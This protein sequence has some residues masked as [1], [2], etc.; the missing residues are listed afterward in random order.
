MS[1]GSDIRKWAEKAK[2]GTDQVIRAS[3]IDVSTRII[4]RTPVG[5]PAQWQ[6]KYP[7]KGYV[8]GTARGNWFASINNPVTA[9]S[10]SV[11][12]ESNAINAAAAMTANAT[13]NVFYLTNNLPYIFRLEYQGWS[14]QAPNGMVRV[15]VIEFN[16]ALTKA[17][18]E[19]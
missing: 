14:T 7:P 12:S 18:S 8:G 15:S 6:T 5:D 16:N 1:F 2:Q 19:L 17:I 13:G 9:F 4:K 10:E 11:I 3:L